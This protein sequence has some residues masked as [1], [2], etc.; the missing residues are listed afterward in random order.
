MHV[1]ISLASEKG[2]TAASIG[3]YMIPSV[4]VISQGC[5]TQGMKSISTISHRSF[6]NAKSLY[7]R[8]PVRR[9]LNEDQYGQQLGFRILITGKLFMIKI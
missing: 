9:H 1:Y 6:N 2:I 5:L 4:D 3:S 7:P 8:L